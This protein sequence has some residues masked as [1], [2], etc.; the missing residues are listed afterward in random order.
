MVF[1]LDKATPQFPSSITFQ[2]LISIQSINIHHCIID[3]GASTCIMPKFVRKKLGYSQLKPSDI[4]LRAYDGC[5][6]TLV[7]LYPSV[8]VKLARKTVLIDIEVLDA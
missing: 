3:E 8:P 5:P 1:D 7:S 6:S 4:T 2:I